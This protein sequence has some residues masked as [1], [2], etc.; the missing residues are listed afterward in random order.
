MTYNNCHSTVPCNQLSEQ[1]ILQLS[2]YYAICLANGWMG[3][4][5][6]VWINLGVEREGYPVLSVVKEFAT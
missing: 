6:D 1:S 2:L 4:W 3:G 5:V